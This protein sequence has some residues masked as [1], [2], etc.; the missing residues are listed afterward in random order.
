MSGRR[1]VQSA[2]H[3]YVQGRDRVWEHARK[4]GGAAPRAA[5]EPEFG[6]VPE[7]PRFGVGVAKD[8]DF[9]R[10]PAAW[11]DRDDADEA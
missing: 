8:L 2:L 5:R 9:R 1:N 4:F 11:R 7:A 6:S 3:A 10:G